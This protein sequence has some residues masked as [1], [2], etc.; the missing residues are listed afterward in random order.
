MGFR[1]FKANVLFI[2]H[3]G[4]ILSMRIFGEE[5]LGLVCLH[6]SGLPFCSAVSG[7]CI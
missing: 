5:S 1:I 4:N 6:T 2:S 3:V 7:D